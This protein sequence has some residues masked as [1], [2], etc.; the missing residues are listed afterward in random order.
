M[1]SVAPICTAASPSPY[2]EVLHV[3][4]PHCTCRTRAHLHCSQPGA[5]REGRRDAGAGSL[6]PARGLAATLWLGPGRA[7]EG[8][9]RGPPGPLPHGTGD[10]RR[11]SRLLQAPLTARPLQRRSRGVSVLSPNVS[12]RN[13]P[14]T[15]TFSM[16]NCYSYSTNCRDGSGAAPSLPAGRKEQGR[17]GRRRVPRAQHWGLAREPALPPPPA[18]SQAP[19]A[20]APRI[21]D[22][23]KCPPDPGPDRPRV[24]PVGAR[25]LAPSAPS[26]TVRC[27]SEKAGK[28]RWNGAKRKREAAAGYSRARWR[29]R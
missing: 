24:H 8:E 27:T 28:K 6:P 15:L 20:R 13:P 2:A 4:D 14:Q 7:E 12:K 18:S 10:P 5:A 17:R 11:W 1:P 29:R 23:P 16:F 22:A 19:R 25:R 9:T 3:L 21:R 26:S